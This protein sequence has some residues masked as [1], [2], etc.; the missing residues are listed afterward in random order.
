MKIEPRKTAALP[1]YA[2]IMAAAVMLTGCRYDGEVALAGEAQ[3]I[4]TQVQI[5]GD[6][7]VCPDPVPDDDLQLGGDVALTDCVAD[8]SEERLRETFAAHGIT[9]ERA[10]APADVA[11]EYQAA[12]FID[13]E[14]A[15]LVCFYDKGTAA[16]N[17]YAEAGAVQYDWGF[18][19]TAQYPRGEAE[20]TGFRSAFI[21]VSPDCVGAIP[22]ETA[23]QIA[24]ALLNDTETAEN[25]EVQTDEN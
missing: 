9:L 5:D 11:G 19:G 3:P 17:R 16:E 7:Q 2:M 12:W 6:M 13:R 25:T 10:D 15:V 14:N 24:N 23:E 18:A 1:K 21:A 8:S 20:Q 4:D 22:A